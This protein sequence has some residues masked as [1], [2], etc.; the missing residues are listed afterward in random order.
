MA[1]AVLLVGGRHV[2]IA[3]GWDL[4][5]LVLAVTFVVGMRGAGIPLRTP[6][7][8]SAV[9]AGLAVDLAIDVV[10]LSLLAT[11]A[12]SIVASAIVALHRIR[13]DRRPARGV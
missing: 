1:L 10:G 8:L 6:A 7:L 5:P 3:E 9:L 11:V 2:A 13:L 12:I 4:G